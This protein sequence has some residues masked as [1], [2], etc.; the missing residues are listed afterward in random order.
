M[1]EK[2]PNGNQNILSRKK[3]NFALFGFSNDSLLLFGLIKLAEVQK[4]ETHPT[5]CLSTF[6]SNVSKFYRGLNTLWQNESKT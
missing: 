2:L 5:R 6:K 3:E 1:S 4:N